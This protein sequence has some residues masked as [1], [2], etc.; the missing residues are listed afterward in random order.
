ME[1]TQI[2]DFFKQKKAFLWKIVVGCIVGSY[3]LFG[4]TLLAPRLSWHGMVVDDVL[5]WLKNRFGNVDFKVIF[6]YNLKRLRFTVIRQGFWNFSL[7][8]SYL[9]ATCEK[10]IFN[11]SDEAF[12][13]Y[14]SSGGDFLRG[15][16]F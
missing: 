14:N 10:S 1:T 13:F 2:I 16:T 6:Q 7:L 11:F 12:V 15:T 8:R 9:Y 5:E 4:F 3:K